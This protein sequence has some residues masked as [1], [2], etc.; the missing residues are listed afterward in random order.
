MKPWRSS[1]CLL[2]V[3]AGWAGCSG[4]KTSPVHGKVTLADGSPLQDGVVTFDDATNH[5]SA[6]GFT[7]ADGSYTMTT[8]KTGDGVPAGTYTVTVHH[9]L[10]Q[11]SSQK[12]KKGL[13]HPRYESRQKSGLQCIVKPGDNTFDIPLDKP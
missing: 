13:F 4:V 7:A 9:P 10:P 1:V 11:D 3:M 6:R 8:V 2:V 5:V 12:E